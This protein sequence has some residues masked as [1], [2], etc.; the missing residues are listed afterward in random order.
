VL[1]KLRLIDK[2]KPKWTNPVHYSGYEDR[3][4]ADDPINDP[5]DPERLR[6]DLRQVA[7]GRGV[8]R[9]RHG[10]VLEGRHGLAGMRSWDPSILRLSQDCDSQGI[11]EPIPA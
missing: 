5:T 2:W 3:E 11:G 10:M 4:H 9:A 8:Q 6:K 7:Q 1:G